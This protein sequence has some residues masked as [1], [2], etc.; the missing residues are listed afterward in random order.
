[1][2]F[3]E[4]PVNPGRGRPRRGNLPFMGP[5]ISTRTPK[6]RSR[7][8]LSSSRTSDL[9]WGR[10]HE[11]IILNS[12]GNKKSVSSKTTTSE[13]DEEKIIVAITE[14]RGEARCEVGIAAVNVSRPILMLCQTSD[15]QSYS[16]TLTKLNIINPHMIIYPATF[17]TTGNRLISEIK[18]R[19]PN[20]KI[21]A[22]QRKAFNKANGLD[23]LYKICI[24]HSFPLILMIKN[25][26][27]AL[28][29]ASGLLTYL[30]DILYIYYSTNSI[31]IDYQA[32]EGYAIIDIATADRLE[33]VCSNQPAQ[34]NRYSSLF[35]IMNRCLTRVGTRHMRTIILQPLYS[36]KKINERLDCVEELINKKEIL[37]AMQGVLPK[38]SSVDQLL[39]LST[40]V[41]EDPQ[42]CS[43]RQLNYLLLLNGVVDTI[44]PLNEALK[45]ATQPFFLNFRETLCDENFEA[46]KNLL[47]QTIH[48]DAYSARGQQADQQRIWAIKP[49]I[50]GLLDLVRKTFSE[51]IEDMREYIKNLSTKYDLPLTLSNNNKKGYHIVLSLNQNQRKHM[52]SSDLPEEFIQV[53]RSANSFT[54]KT[55]ELV[56]LSTRIDDI[57]RDLFSLSN[58][59]LYK[60]IL[61]I[62]QYASLFYELV[63]GISYL[64]ILQS[65]AEASQANSWVRPTFAEYTDVSHGH[66]PLLDFLCQKTPVS[67]PVATCEHYNLHII[68]GP[69]GAGKSIFIRQVM[70]LQIMAQAG[71]FVPAEKAIFRPSDKMFARISNEDDMESNA[72]SFVLEMTEVDYILTTMTDNSL[73]IIDELCRST[74][75]EEGTAIAMQICDTLARSKAFTFVTTHFIMLTKLAELFINIKVWQLETVPIGETRDPKALKLNFKFSLVPGVT[76]IRGYGIYMVRGIWPEEV[77]KH[78]DQLQESY[79][80][81]ANN[82][83]F[84]SIDKRVRLRYALDCKLNKLKLRKRFTLAQLNELIAEFDSEMQK[85]GTED[86]EYSQNIINQFQDVSNNGL[87]VLDHSIFDGSQ[88]QINPLA[89]QGDLGIQQQSQG[90]YQSMPRMRGLFTPDISSQSTEIDNNNFFNL[91]PNNEPEINFNYDNSQCS[92]TSLNMRERVLSQEIRQDEPFFQ[93]PSLPRVPPSVQESPFIGTFFRPFQEDSTKTS[94]QIQHDA[95]GF[96]DSSSLFSISK[97]YAGDVAHVS[98][99]RLSF[100]FPRHQENDIDIASI[101]EDLESFAEEIE[102]NDENNDGG[103]IQNDDLSQPSSGA[104]SQNFEAILQQESKNLFQAP[105]VRESPFTSTFLRPLQADSG[106]TST[107][108]VSRNQLD[109]KIFRNSSLTDRNFN[110]QEDDLDIAS[111][112]DNLKPFGEEIENNAEK[113][114]V[115]YNDDLSQQFIEA[116]MF[117]DEM[118]KPLFKAVPQQ[119]PQSSLA[120]TFFRPLEGDSKKTTLGK[121]EDDALMVQNMEPFVGK[122][123]NKDK[124]DISSEVTK[125]QTKLKHLDIF[126]RVRIKLGPGAI[127]EES[128]K[129]DTNINDEG[130]TVR[131]ILRNLHVSMSPIQPIIESRLDE[132][133]ITKEKGQSEQVESDTNFDE[134]AQPPNDTDEIIEAVNNLETEDSIKGDKQNDFDVNFEARNGG[135]MEED[136]KAACTVNQQEE[137]NTTEDEA[138]KEKNSDSKHTSDSIITQGSIS[139]SPFVPREDDSSANHEIIEDEGENKRNDNEGFKE[140]KKQEEIPKNKETI[141]ENKRNENLKRI[142]E[143]IEIF[144]GQ[145]G[146]DMQHKNSTIDFDLESHLTNPLFPHVS[147][148]G[149]EDSIQYQTYDTDFDRSTEKCF[150]PNAKEPIIPS[151]KVDLI[152]EIILKR[153]NTEQKSSNN[154]KE[155][156]TKPQEHYSRM[157]EVNTSLSKINVK[158]KA[159]KVFTPSKK[160]KPSSESSNSK[161]STPSLKSSDSKKSI[162]E[163]SKLRNLDGDF[164][165]T[166]TSSG[167]KKVET[168]STSLSSASKKRDLEKLNRSSTKKKTKKFVAPLKKRSSENNE[169]VESVP[170]KKSLA[171]LLRYP[172]LSQKAIRDEFFEQDKK[173]YESSGSSVELARVW[174]E[175]LKRPPRPTPKQIQQTTC[176]ATIRKTQEGVLVIPEEK[177]KATRSSSGNFLKSFVSPPSSVNMNIF[178]DRNAKTFERFIRSDKKDYKLFKFNFGQPPSQNDEENMF[179][180]Q[181]VESAEYTQTS[182]SWT[183]V[184]KRSDELDNPTMSLNSTSEEFGLTSEK[185]FRRNNSEEFGSFMKFI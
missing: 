44:E 47:R 79:V 141:E 68:T 3:N 22:Y 40:L 73:I 166:S 88:S 171:P 19:L 57:L 29:A 89:S 103:T 70:L 46:I 30:Q 140:L 176:L 150:T 185:L 102:N 8:C 151:K 41:P 117:Q 165:T 172:A 54:M 114:A 80:P 159:P 58:L 85:L 25:R 11:S 56:N 184:R 9:P 100:S 125:T 124:T 82:P 15:S 153:K 71:C 2:N 167:P 121:Q 99:D 10:S 146:Q 37:L 143:V 111:L 39:S 24:S 97:R 130:T 178:S 95:K 35:G 6:S 77:M 119:V 179:N 109:G 33:L 155:S 60:T 180:F 66:H 83:N 90:M 158:R 106:K 131:P 128:I 75:M 134:Y 129:D 145:D 4:A 18:K 148:M 110:M 74:S 136:T 86:Y 14:G 139:Y 32:S 94:T 28:A 163:A 105:Q 87:V 55:A 168:S 135:L 69:N 45:N 64:D 52:K 13:S 65:L 59:T 84:P 72:S 7:S 170:L 23:K 48:E 43:N 157:E 26:Y 36:S 34:A 138:E 183:F 113:D 61:E 154:V 81:K 20:K 122:I 62:K 93:V 38:L 160:I 49:E 164:S 107:P 98:T 181:R 152:S 169:V 182:Q 144:S 132:P 27:Y 1:M 173:F 137:N 16:N 63:E 112:V 116:I 162:S 123:V 147:L 78:V 108:M 92:T 21:V 174:E 115:I 91:P 127:S 67:N 161:K 156:V 149:E 17:E 126:P 5:P 177:K 133:E 50:N 118:N 101:V 51:R 104:I 42:G 96:E 53:F 175:R 76:S 142:D 120:S 12:P 31:K